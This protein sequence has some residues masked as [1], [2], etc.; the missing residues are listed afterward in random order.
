MEDHNLLQANFRS[1][2]KRWG[3]VHQLSSPHY[4]QSNGL[5]ESAVKAMKRIVQ[6]T[7]LNGVL[8]V[9]AFCKGIIEFRNT[10]RQNG[11][12]PAEFVFGREMRAVVPQFRTEY[13][14][15]WI[16]LADAVDNREA[17]KFDAVAHYNSDAKK[18]SELRVGDRVLIQDD[19]NHKWSKCGV[20]V[21][22]G[23]YRKYRVKLPS[24]RVI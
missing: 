22:A 19:I 10:P 5:A 2:M 23:R 21:E 17:E 14:S 7:T 8:D 20:I 16:A 6:K 9:E 15:R 11:K 12:S 4:P 24:G 13:L 18:L 3:V 1:F